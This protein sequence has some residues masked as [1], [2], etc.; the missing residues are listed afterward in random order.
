MTTTTVHQRN[1]KSYNG[2]KISTNIKSEKNSQNKNQKIPLCSY[3]ELP[4]WQKDNEWILHGHLLPGIGYLLLL[5]FFTD[6]VLIPYLVSHMS[7]NGHEAIDV[8]D[9]LMINFYLVGAFLC[10]MCSSFFHC[11]KQHSK[12]H[13][14]MWSKADYMGIVILISASIISLLYYGYYD[15]LSYFKI[16]TIITIILGSIC[17]V[18]VLNDKFNE[19]DFKIYRA[20]FFILFGFSGILPVGMGFLKFGIVE[21]C[22]RVQFNYLLLEAVC[23][24]TGALIYGFKLPEAFA[25]GK[26]DCFGNSHQIFHVFVVLGSLF[27]LRA[28]VGSFI[29]MHSGYHTNNLLIF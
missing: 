25:P 15:H 19:K 1:L 23:Y 10:L 17:S 16:F 8:I 18:F 6:L 28:V 20:T 13:S 2:S 9:Y 5:L 12:K 3:S 14:D 7:M 27:H 4:E 11:F 22:K 24:I 21:S 26:F 29:L